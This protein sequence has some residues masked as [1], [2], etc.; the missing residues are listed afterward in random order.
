MSLAWVHYDPN[1]VHAD[2]GAGDCAV[3]AIAKALDISW[4]Q[5]YAKLSA[6][7]FLM[8]DI[9]NAD[10]VWGAVLREA[11]FVREIIPNTCP[12]CY[13]IEAFCEDHPEGT[14][15]LKSENHVSTVVDGVLYDSWN[16]ETKV[17][18]YYWTRKEEENGAV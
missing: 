7:G 3:R 18:V 4:E 1:P 11:G 5:A 6:T 9:M 16:S 15:V 17:P 10:I 8:G 13:T 2:A 12:D 14:F